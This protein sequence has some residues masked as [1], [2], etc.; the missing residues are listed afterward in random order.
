MVGAVCN[1][2]KTIDSNEG[3]LISSHFK[4]TMTG[5]LFMSILARACCIMVLLAN[6]VSKLSAALLMVSL[7]L[8]GQEE[9]D[10]LLAQD[11]WLSV[12]VEAKELFHYRKDPLAR[13]R[14]GQNFL[15]GGTSDGY[16][17]VLD[18]ACGTS[19]FSLKVG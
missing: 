3:S 15:L 5:V 1:C 14:K 12:E 8:F 16:L 2:I 19:L 11:R 10:E 6:S 13:E 7:S 17:A 18:Q 4:E 9:I